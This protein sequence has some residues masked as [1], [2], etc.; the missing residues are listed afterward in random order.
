[1]LYG[2]CL[3]NVSTARSTIN[4]L[5]SPSKKNIRKFDDKRKFLSSPFK[6]FKDKIYKKFIYKTTYYFKV[7]QII[8]QE[9]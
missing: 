2:V 7:Y 3:A 1:M 4:F 6:S 9:K 5:T 8:R